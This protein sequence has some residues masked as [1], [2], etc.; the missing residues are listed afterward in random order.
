MSE[1]AREKPSWREATDASFAQWLRVTIRRRVE[2]AAWVFVAV[3]VVARGVGIAVL[4]GTAENAP[5]ALWMPV[6]IGI[7]AATGA[8]MRWLPIARRSPVAV[9]GVFFVAMPAAAAAHLSAL[10]G[11]D[12]PFFYASYLIPPMTTVLPVALRARVVMTIASTLAFVLTFVLAHP[13]HLPYRMI[14]I[15]AVSLAATVVISIVL[16]HGGHQLVKERHDLAAELERR[17]LDEARRAERRALARVLHD[18][19]AQ[20]GTA[21]RM[22][23]TGLARKASG[24]GVAPEDLAYL[25][26]LL[27]ALDR[28][29]RRIVTNLREADD[30]SLVERLERMCAL[31]E[32]GTSVRIERAFDAVDVPAHTREVVFRGLQEAI[33]NALKHA[34]ARTIIVRLERAGRAIVA[35]VADDGQ[36][37]DVRKQ[38]EAAGFGLVG[39]RERVAALGGSLDLVSGPR[40]TTLTISLPVGRASDG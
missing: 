20:L 33:T 4:H 30:T 6:Q 37:F 3:L 28:S 1:L 40:G 14:H 38:E 10:G 36:G 21:A 2:V 39:M 11:F 17:A 23:L 35:S 32:R 18:D 13:E 16:G 26:E 5:G 22:E 8:V 27:E 12:G 19:F 25:R 29:S 31:V 7:A 15:P 24:Q 34:Q 9:A